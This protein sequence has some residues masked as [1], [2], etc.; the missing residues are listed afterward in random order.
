MSPR[1]RRS[2]SLA[3]AYSAIREALT[4]AGLGE[5]LDAQLV[6][7][8]GDF[9]VDVCRA[10]VGMEA[11]DGAGEVRKECCQD[12]Q[13][14]V[15]RDPLD[16]VD[17]LKLGDFVDE[18]DL[19]EALDAVQISLMDGIDAQEAWA[20]LGGVRRSPMVI[21]TGRVLVTVPRWR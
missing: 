5:F 21:L 14:E 12:W 19:V 8:H 4:P 17:E 3:S 9:L 18:V 2:S 20:A 10:I 13:Q 6:E 15:F 16:R 1:R 7:Q 11:E